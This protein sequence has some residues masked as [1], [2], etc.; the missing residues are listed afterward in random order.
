MS[1]PLQLDFE[2]KN[3]THKYGTHYYRCGGW[4]ITKNSF[5][6]IALN[7]ELRPKPRKKKRRR[8]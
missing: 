3:E 2:F 8:R 6:Y 4:F 5:V 1:A 7:G